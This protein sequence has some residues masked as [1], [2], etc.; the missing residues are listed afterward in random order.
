MT[1]A[2]VNC[3]TTVRRTV[4]MTDPPP[5]ADDGEVVVIGSAVVRVIVAVEGDI[6]AGWPLDVPRT[7][8]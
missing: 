1:T 6:D 7:C 2:D 8:T 3:E 5:W 4:E